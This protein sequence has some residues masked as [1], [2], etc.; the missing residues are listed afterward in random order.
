MSLR[1][2]P[3][4]S[5]RDRERFIDLPWRLR[6]GDPD[7]WKNWIP[8]LRTQIRDLL[9]D[10]GNPFYR[11]ASRQLFVAWRNGVP[12]GRVAAIENREHNRF[13]RDRVGFFGF[14]DCAPDPEAAL[15]LMDAAR[16]WLAA[17]GLEL[18][19]GPVNPST[20]HDCGVLVRGFRHPPTFLTPWNPRGYGELLAE[21]GLEPARDLLAYWI[22]VS[23]PRFQLPPRFEAQALR[24][25]ERQGMS[26]RDVDLRRWDRELDL[27]WEIYNEAWEPN[28]GFVPL[29]REEFEYT[30]GDMKSLI[31]PEFAFIAEV[32]GEA[33]GFMLILPDL[34]HILKGIP[35]GRLF[36]TG[37]L[38]ILL[39]RRKLRSGRVIALGVK[40]RYRSRSIFPLFAHEAFRRGRAMGALGAEASW[41]LEDNDAI[42][43]PL[44]SMGLRPHRRWRIFEGP[45]EFA[46]AGEAA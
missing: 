4:E 9:D 23:D 45:L 42:N 18:I 29:T 39:G 6:Q 31:Y 5:R 28:W 41:I 32:D 10:G 35:D 15:A 11:N 34:N 16:E 12:V 46:G 22:P 13:H 43:R 40:E 21:A 8:P 25:R 38:R 14:F 24:A 37:L 19:R 2:L 44:R 36:P 30:A 7:G 27:C 26:F 3:A 17:R 20:N 33:A 1:V